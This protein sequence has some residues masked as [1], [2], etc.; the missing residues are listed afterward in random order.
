MLL[1]SEEHDGTIKKHCAGDCLEEPYNLV[2]FSD[3]Y[4]IDNF[5]HIKRN[6]AGYSHLLEHHVVRA[7]R[8]AQSTID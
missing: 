4:I 1:M 5:V 2:D 3:F 6:H 8:S 7:V